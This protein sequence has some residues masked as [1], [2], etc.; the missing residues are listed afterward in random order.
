MREQAAFGERVHLALELRI[1]RRHQRGR[2][3]RRLR[4]R[5]QH[6][7]FPLV[8]VRAVLR[9]LGHAA[10]HDRPV[11]RVDRARLRF[12]QPIQRGEVVRHV[13]LGR[14]DDHRT[15][16]RHQIAGDHRSAALLDQ[17]QVPARVARQMKGAPAA[18]ADLESLA[19]LDD[20]LEGKVEQLR[21]LPCGRD[22]QPEHL[23]TGNVIEVV[24]G[25]EDS[26]RLAAFAL[27]A[28]ERLAQDLLLLG[29]GRAG[30]DDPQLVVAEQEAVGMRGGR[31]RRGAQRNEDHAAL[32]LDP[33][34]H[35]LLDR[36]LPGRLIGR[37]QERQRVARPG[38]VGQ[39][40][41]RVPGRRM[42]QGE[43]LFPSAQ[44]LFGLDPLA[45]GELAGPDLGRF[46]GR[47]LDQV[48][49]R[50][51]SDRH[52]RRR[53]PAAGGREALRVDREAV[54][55]EELAELSARREQRLACDLAVLR[56]DARSARHGQ[57]ARLLEELAGCGGEAGRFLGVEPFGILQRNRRV[58][59]VHAPARKGVVVTNSLR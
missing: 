12:Q 22:G 46:A 24:M 56:R 14:V 33:F 28:I 23:R 27:E 11:R 9:E 18:G 10:R 50:V 8:A 49:T 45:L 34:H 36:Q 16:A 2:R 19:V 44:S 5:G 21:R 51:E 53:H 6:Q 54:P 40:F 20:A 31:Q 35:V 47:H 59:E 42:E 58:V 1:G 32:E 7:L 29:P 48:E 55:G 43:A 4:E 37:G 41:Q 39:R 38:D 15:D 57:D 30:I 52:R 17:A 13:A 26:H 3:R 25:E